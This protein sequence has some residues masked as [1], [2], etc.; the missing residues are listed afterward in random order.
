MDYP[1]NSQYDKWLSISTQAKD[2]LM[3]LST[4][5]ALALSQDQPPVELELL[6]AAVSPISTI[7]RT[8]VE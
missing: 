7:G 5:D 8:G 1:L 3:F 2:E 4:A 6:G